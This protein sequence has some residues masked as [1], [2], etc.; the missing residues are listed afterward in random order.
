MEETYTKSAGLLED[1]R[2]AYGKCLPYLETKS[3]A[4]IEIDKESLEKS[5]TSSVLKKLGFSDKGIDEMV[6]MD[7]EEFQKAFREKR[8]MAHNNG[9]RQKV[10]PQTEIKHYIE[11]LGWEYVK[12]LNP[13]ESI[14]KL[15]D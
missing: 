4:I 14:V 9:H 7:D 1:G 2:D 5:I 12:E 11:D 6:D 15:L 3:N 10:I 13:R 8:G